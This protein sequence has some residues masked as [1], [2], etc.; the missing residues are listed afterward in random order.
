MVIE[1]KNKYSLK[2]QEH[3]KSLWLLLYFVQFRLK[4][5]SHCHL[6]WRQWFFRICPILYRRKFWR[7][8]VTVGLFRNDTFIFILCG[9]L[10]HLSLDFCNFLLESYFHALVL[11]RFLW[12]RRFFLAF[13]LHLFE[14]GFNFG[15]ECLSHGTAHCWGIHS[16]FVLFNPFQ[17]C[18]LDYVLPYCW[19]AYSWWIYGSISRTIPAVVEFNF[20]AAKSVQNIQYSAHDLKI[21]MVLR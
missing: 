18:F 2:I 1:V 13:G 15:S 21:G 19:R 4:G 17:E 6:A 10:V 20:L 7:I 3:V 5:P 11:I 12:C 8:E 9:H 16:L 14:F